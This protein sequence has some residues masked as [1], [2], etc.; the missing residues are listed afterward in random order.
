ML[1]PRNSAAAP[2]NDTKIKKWNTKYNLLPASEKEK[3][4]GIDGSVRILNLPNKSSSVNRTLRFM[5]FFG[6]IIVTKIDL[7]NL[8][9][10]WR[11]Q[12]EEYELIR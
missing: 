3:K 7:V 10:A 6:K 4:N 8:S 5:R 11:R 2:P 9:K 12:V 1:N